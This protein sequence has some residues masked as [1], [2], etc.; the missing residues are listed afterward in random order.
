MII[1]GWEKP[2][3]LQS[4]TSPNGPVAFVF[5]DIQ[6]FKSQKSSYRTLRHAKLHPAP[7]QTAA[8]SNKVLILG[9][10]TFPQQFVT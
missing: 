9:V 10:L 7:C 8:Y 4:N 2:D 6:L 5:S 1:S 3:Q